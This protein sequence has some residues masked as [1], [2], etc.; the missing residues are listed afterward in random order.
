MW[1]KYRER[2]FYQPTVGKEYEEGGEQIVPGYNSLY[3]IPHQMHIL[4]HND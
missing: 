1:D 3:C 2:W 4:M